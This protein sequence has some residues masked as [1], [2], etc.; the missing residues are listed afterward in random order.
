MLTSSI[1]YRRD[2]EPLWFKANEIVRHY[3]K[4]ADCIAA[5]MGADCVEVEH[6]KHPKA[7]LFCLLCKRYQQHVSDMASYETPCSQMHRDAAIKACHLGGSHI[8]TCP[9]GIFF[10]TSPF[11][12]GERFAG[13]FF[14]SVMSSAGKQQTLDK[15]FD[16]CKGDVSRAE[17]AQHIDAVP[18]KTGE[19]VKTL[20][21]VMLMCARHISSHESFWNDRE[22]GLWLKSDLTDIQDKERL[23]LASLRR[24]DSTEAQKISQDMMNSL[25]LV[26]DGNLNQL[27]L[28]AI[29]MVIFLSRNG[30]YSGINEE[31]AGTNNRYIK[32]IEDSKTAK[33]VTKNLCLAVEQMEGNIFSFRGV[34]HASALRKAERFIWENYTRKISLKEVAGISGL[35]APYFSTVFKEEMGENFSNYLNRLRVEK[36]AAMLRETEYPINGISLSCGFEDQSWFSK[37]F[38]AFTGV[39]PCK[40][41]DLG[42]T[43]LSETDHLQMAGTTAESWLDCRSADSSP[44]QDNQRG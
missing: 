39:S 34:R 5:V 42:G 27:R 6:S 20:A 35:S 8:Y 15:L 9:V 33:E 2:L 21:R 13:A 38:K 4:A 31:T 36:A 24:G 44:V 1:I 29:E 30:L 12:V 18:A 7:N 37:I 23:L 28:K 40:Y 3:E 41:R 14:S 25:D 19:E 32:R 11:F 10:W 16:I 22:Q 26:F 43:V 17:I